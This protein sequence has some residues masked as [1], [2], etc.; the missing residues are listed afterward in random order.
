MDPLDFPSANTLHRVPTQNW[1]N[2]QS[3]SGYPQ[4]EFYVL[5]DEILSLPCGRSSGHHAVRPVRGWQAVVIV[6]KFS[7]VYW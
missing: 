4:G 7:S 6:T 3:G 2:D 1:P 5:A